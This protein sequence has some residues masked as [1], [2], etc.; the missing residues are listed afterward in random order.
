MELLKGIH[1][2][3]ACS[4]LGESDMLFSKSAFVQGKVF[5]LRWNDGF[6]SRPPHPEGPRACDS[7]FNPG[8]CQQVATRQ[9]RALGGFPST[10]FVLGGGHI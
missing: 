1:T 6:G 5:L 10:V 7:T 3:S 4:V 9:G 2:E 8:I